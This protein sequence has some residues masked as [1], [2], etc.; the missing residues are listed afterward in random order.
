MDLCSGRPPVLFPDLD[1]G[2]G[3]GFGHD[4]LPL[5]APLSSPARQRQR[6]ADLTRTGSSFSSIS[7]GSAGPVFRGLPLS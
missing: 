3:T 2:M 1:R 4:S 5:S 7:N 6:S